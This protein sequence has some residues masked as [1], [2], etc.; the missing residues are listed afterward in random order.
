[1]YNAYVNIYFH[2][3]LIKATDESMESYYKYKFNL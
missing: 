1:M 2:F 3:S